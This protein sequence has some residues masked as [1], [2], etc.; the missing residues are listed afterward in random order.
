MIGFEVGE[1]RYVLDFPSVRP[2]VRDTV[3]IARALSDIIQLF[4]AKKSCPNYNMSDN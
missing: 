3:Q 4:D 2:C 1:S